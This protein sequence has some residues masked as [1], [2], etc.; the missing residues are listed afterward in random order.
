MN[1]ETLRLVFNLQIN[2][3]EIQSNYFC[4]LLTQ[5]YEY[6]EICFVLLLRIEK[7]KLGSTGATELF[8][9]KFKK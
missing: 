7:N 9:D 4:M 3:L 6:Y 5:I 8:F 2:M 1:N